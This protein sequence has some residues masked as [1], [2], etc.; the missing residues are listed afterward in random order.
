MLIGLTGCVSMQ[1]RKPEHKWANWFID[2]NMSVLLSEPDFKD[3]VVL[4][5]LE[6]ATVQE[7][8]ANWAVISHRLHQEFI[9]KRQTV[10]SQV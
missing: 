3:G 6:R 10:S 8:S 5:C 7:G 4:H 2:I 9:P 1:R